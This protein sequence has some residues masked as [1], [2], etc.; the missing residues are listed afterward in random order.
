[1]YAR[2]PCKANTFTP[3]ADLEDALT[4]VE[5]ALPAVVSVTGEINTPRLPPLTAILKA[6]RKPTRTWEPADI[7]ITTV[8]VGAQASVIRMLSNLAPAQQRK[9]IIF[10]NTPDASADELLRALER[11]GVL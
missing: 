2:S 11:E 3:R 7:G 8:E 6:A 5:C 1:M 4:V 10:E 9:G